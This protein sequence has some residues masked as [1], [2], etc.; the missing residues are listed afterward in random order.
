MLSHLITDIFISSSVM[1]LAYISAWFIAVIDVNGQ[2]N[3]VDENVKVTED[4]V[5]F[6]PCNVVGDMRYFIHLL[7]LEKHLLCCG[8]PQHWYDG[9]ESE[10]CVTSFMYGGVLGLSLLHVWLH[11]FRPLS[12]LHLLCLEKHLL[13]C[14]QPQHWYDGCES[15]WLYLYHGLCVC[16]SYMG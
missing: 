2:T 4:P 15:E 11:N 1:F 9:C 10:I 5:A 3:I 8:Q 13:C 16:S 14:G 7:C 12:L 6:L